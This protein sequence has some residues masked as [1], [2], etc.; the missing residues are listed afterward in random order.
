MMPSRIA[1]VGG[2]RWARNY[3]R[4][5]SKSPDLV[6]SVTVIS[7]RNADGMRRWIAAESLP[8][9]VAQPLDSAGFDAAIIANAASDHEAA[10]A[11]FLKARVPVLIEKPFA[12]S[13]AGAVRLTELA[14]AEGVY[15]AVALVFKFARYL[16][17][18]AALLPDRSQISSISI[19]WTDPKDESRYGERKS[20]DPSLP[21]AADVLPHIVSVLDTLYVAK[22]I[23]CMDVAVKRAGAETDIE[24]S[25]DGTPCKV[26][27]ARNSEKRVRLIEVI[28]DR[29][30][31]VLDFSVEP[32]RIA[33]NGE[34]Q[35]GDPDWGNGPSPLARLAQ[36][37][38]TA[39]GGG[40]RDHRLDA[41][42]GLM[43]S[44]VTDEALRQYDA[45]LVEWLASGQI[46]RP[47]LDYA[48]AE[49]NA[50]R[51][52]EGQSSVDQLIAA[53]KRRANAR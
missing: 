2:G 53:V 42:L 11:R 25:V 19:T 20:Y 44:S 30:Q 52:G 26:R 46:D 51:T 36:S 35:S 43:A 48:I 6:R 13:K 47:D 39:V 17:R 12:M 28:A 16:D 21:V 7:P 32:G 9:D 14:Q 45:A 37:F 29:V 33:A 50:T 41:N 49:L 3:A 1:L 34:S 4:V 24:L 18:F 10:A 8:Y 22:K 23:V 5:L 15:L 31:H 27:L 38:L 40:A